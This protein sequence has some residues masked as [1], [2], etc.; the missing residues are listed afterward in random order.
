M[1]NTLSS[2]LD[3]SGG[4]GVI[5]IPDGYQTPSFP[6]LYIPTIDSTIEQRGVFL[7][8]AEAIWHFT[9]YWTIL[10]LGALFLICS[11][12]AS[13]TL[14][15]S[16]TVSR[17]SSQQRSRK[18]SLAFVPLGTDAI[19]SGG[20]PPPP[21][22]PFQ[23]KTGDSPLTKNLERR[24][25]KRPPLWPILVLPVVAVSVAALISIVTGT[26]VGFALAAVYSAGGFSMSTWVPFLWA[27]IQVLVLIISSY[28]TLTSIL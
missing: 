8:E 23:S 11:L 6:S 5:S 20:I 27:L 9:L 28:S 1:G 17:P 21:L 15:L 14:L 2:A 13:F 22:Q 10:L 24:K 25:G 12:F 19:S 4:R 3:P 16:L 26:V 7:Y 18:P